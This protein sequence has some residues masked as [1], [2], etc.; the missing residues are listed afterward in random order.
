MRQNIHP[1]NRV[2]AYWKF[3][4]L[5]KSEKRNIKKKLVPNESG[6]VFF[7]RFM[8]IIRTMD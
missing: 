3:E 1:Y 8:H 6:C 5:H 2:G 7:R 4:S